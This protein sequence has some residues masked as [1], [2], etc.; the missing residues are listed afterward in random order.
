VHSIEKFSTNEKINPK[1]MKKLLFQFDYETGPSLFLTMI[2]LHWC[3]MVGSALL[4]LC[5]TLSTLAQAYLTGFCS[6]L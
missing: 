5:Q 3:G 1:E 2:R 4:Q 6:F